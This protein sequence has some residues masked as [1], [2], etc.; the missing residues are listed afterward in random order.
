MLQHDVANL[1]D[2]G[3]FTELFEHAFTLLAAKFAGLETEIE[4]GDSYGW[5]NSG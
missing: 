1:T 2:E 4:S 3:P 5:R